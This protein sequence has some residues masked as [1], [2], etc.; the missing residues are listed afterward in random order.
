MNARKTIP[1][2][3]VLTNP[4]KYVSM[5]DTPTRGILARWIDDKSTDRSAKSTEDDSL[6]PLLIAS[7]EQARAKKAN[8]K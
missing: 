3:S 4:E 5:D 6:A 8:K 1:S 2:W 7:I